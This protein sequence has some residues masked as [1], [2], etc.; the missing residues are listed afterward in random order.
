MLTGV[1]VCGRLCVSMCV[2][3]F[4]F[5]GAYVSMSLSVCLSVRVF[6]AH[7]NHSI[8][9]VLSDMDIVSLL[10]MAASDLVSD[11][12]TALFLSTTLP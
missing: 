10:L 6:P 11:A 7:F 12:C 3:P 4:V 8:C 5:V 1:D 9:H 2:R